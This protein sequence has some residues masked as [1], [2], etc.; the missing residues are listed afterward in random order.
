M[1]AARVQVST[2]VG[3]RIVA[4]DVHDNQHVAKGYVRLI[5][6]GKITAAREYANRVGWIRVSNDTTDISREG[7]AMTGKLTKLGLDDPLHPALSPMSVNGPKKR[8]SGQKQFRK[9][10]VFVERRQK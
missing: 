1:Q 4:V 7:R 6:E 10:R 8:K 5:V 2:D 9:K 3:G